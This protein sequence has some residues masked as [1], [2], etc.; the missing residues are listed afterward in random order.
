[1]SVC[2]LCYYTGAVS[3]AQARI[4]VLPEVPFLAELKSEKC[5]WPIERWAREGAAKIRRRCKWV[6]AARRRFAATI[7]AHIVKAAP[8]HAA[9][10]DNGI[11]VPAVVCEWKVGQWEMWLEE[12]AADESVCR[13]AA[14]LKGKKV[15]RY[16]G[17]FYL[18][19]PPACFYPYSQNSCSIALSRDGGTMYIKTR[20]EKSLAFS[21]VRLR[22]VRWGGGW[23]PYTTIRGIT[24]GKSWR[25]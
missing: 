16:I 10:D 19:C 2:S 6:H 13:R 24:N 25:R 14:Q 8:C 12:L 15:K 22:G 21:S 7:R 20:M 17:R 3:T 4:V 11:R 5:L 1:M 18:Y 23:K 9:Y